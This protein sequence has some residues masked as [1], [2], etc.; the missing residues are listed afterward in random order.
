LSDAIGSMAGLW[1]SC[2]KH[3]QTTLARVNEIA[4]ARGKLDM[5]WVAYREYAVPDVLQS[6]V[7]T[8]NPLE[9]ELFLEKYLVTVVEI[10]RRPL[11]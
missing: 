1:K 10:S 5:K 11:R 2:R 9:L 7:W 6:S 3:I 4:D 8:S